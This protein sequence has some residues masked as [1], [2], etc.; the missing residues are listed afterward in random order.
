MCEAGNEPGMVQHDET[1]S[2]DYSSVAVARDLVGERFGGGLTAYNPQ[3]RY[4]RLEK[5]DW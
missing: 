5:S 1:D 2:A 4:R 3:P